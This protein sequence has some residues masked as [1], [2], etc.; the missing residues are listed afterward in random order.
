MTSLQSDVQFAWRMLV[1]RPAFTALAVFTLALGIGATTAIFSAVNPILFESLPYPNSD[2][3]AMIWEGRDAN[4]PSNVGYSTYADIAEQNRSFSAVAAVG[5]AN[6]TLTGRGE[7]QFLVGQRV[8]PSF[9]QVFGVQ[10]AVGRAFSDAENVRGSD[11]VVV[12]SHALWRNRFAGDSSIVGKT[13]TMLENEYRVLGVMPASFENVLGPTTQF[14]IPLRYDRTLP[15]ACRSCRHLRAVALRK[16]DVS[17]AQAQRDLDNLAQ[18]MGREYPTDYVNASLRAANLSDDITRGVRPALLA[19]LGAVAL[20]LL[21]ACLNVMNLLLARAAQRQGEFAVRA[22]LGAG[23][24]RIVR[25]LLVES[26]LL[27]L[28]GGVVGMAVAFAGVRILVALSPANLPRLSAIQIEESVLAFAFAVT[29]VVGIAFGLVPALHAARRNVH[30]TMRSAARTFAGSA[31]LTRSSLVVSEV[32]LAIVLLVGSGLLFRSMER[33]FSVHPGFESHNLLTLQ[34][35]SGAGRLTNDTLVAQFLEQSLS[36]VR[37]LPGVQSAALTSQ[38]PLSDDYD[39]Y[40]VHFESQPRINPQSDGGGFRYAVSE[41][42]FETMEIPLVAGRYFSSADRAGAPNVVII[43]QS[44]A[45]S[46]F[47]NGSALGQRLK[48]G[49]MN[50]PWREVVGVVGDVKQTSLASGEVQ[51]VYV[52]QTQWQFTDYAMT[53]VVRSAQDVSTLAPA[54]RQ[55][56]W[57]VD[58]DQ[59]IIR[60]AT[61]DDLMRERAAERHFALVLF[62]SFAFVALVLAAAGIYGVLAG[63]VAERNREF[64]VRAALGAT[65]RDQISM[66]LRQGMRLTVIG[67]LVG[68]GAALATSRVLSTLLYDVSPV[69]PITYLSVTLAL[70]AVALLACWIPAFRASRT[71]PMDA[72]RAE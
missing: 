55:T 23:R 51:A 65:G 10:P 63:T 28:V 61:A 31:Q 49:G 25:Q 8:T 69:D 3:I 5:T 45:R 1:R 11:R 50:G 15:Q 2:R 24:A 6:G 33:L 29:S 66:V 71:S 26:V 36:N 4:D 64:G 48:L 12:L 32:A 16:A 53:L 67:I 34:I 43:N 56:I 39:Q 57:S 72:L 21:V 54:L 38:L 7:P 58:K 47:G 35:Q 13:V 14:Y 59:P 22:A 40:G 19:V 9:F 70:V 62:E 18:R 20:V 37:T 27:A 41:R 52:P 68:L 44:L 60:I 46:R 30:G 17:E 42:Y